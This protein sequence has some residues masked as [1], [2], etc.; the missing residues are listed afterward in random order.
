MHE[1]LLAPYSSLPSNPYTFSPSLT[2]L[3]NNP[4]TPPNKKVHSIGWSSDGRKLA[5]GSVDQT[6][7]VWYG[8]SFKESMELKAHTG[9]VAQLTWDPNDC[10]KLATASVDKTVRIWDI[11][12]SLRFTLMF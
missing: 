6:A 9:D 8:Q 4:H 2:K 3:T 10:E 12:G 11:K 7:R 1:Y 5:S